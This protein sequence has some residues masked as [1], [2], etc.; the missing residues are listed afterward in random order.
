MT[1]PSWSR[2]PPA[3]AALRLVTCGS[4]A[5][6]PDP[7]DDDGALL[8]ATAAGRRRVEAGDVRLVRLNP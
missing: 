3:G 7:L 2:P 1:V 6:A 8:V 5:H 4:S